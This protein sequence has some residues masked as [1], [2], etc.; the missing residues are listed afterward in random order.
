M[1]GMA[2]W[3]G[4]IDSSIPALD[5]MTWLPICAAGQRH[6]S[7]AQPHPQLVA[8]L[9]P[10]HQ[11]GRLLQQHLQLLQHLP[12]GSPEA[13]QGLMLVVAPR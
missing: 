7:Q 8:G 5:L 9:L 3:S 13:A 1:H 2:T 10:L 6:L 12:Q 4:G 11:K